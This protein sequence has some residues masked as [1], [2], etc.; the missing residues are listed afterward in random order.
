MRQHIPG[1]SVA[2]LI[3]LRMGQ[4]TQPDP[5][6][7]YPRSFAIGDGQSDDD[8]F[9]SVGVP[10]YIDSIIAQI[11]NPGQ[12]NLDQLKASWQVILWQPVGGLLPSTADYLVYTM[13]LPVDGDVA[14]LEIVRSAGLQVSPAYPL[15]GRARLATTEV[16]ILFPVAQAMVTVML[17][18]KAEKLPTTDGGK[19]SRPWEEPLV[20]PK[21]PN[22]V[23][24]VTRIFSG[25]APK[26]PE[27]PLSQDGTN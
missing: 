27:T 8:A 11:R 24:G 18:V 1:N 26:P 6:I 19:A 21:P 25:W 9:I 13:S 3:K 10:L 12:F 7:L 5:E 14:V 20:L 22:E 4:V 16:G 23:V 2:D 15:L 17:A